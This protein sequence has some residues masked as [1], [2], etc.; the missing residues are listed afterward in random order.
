MAPN[1]NFLT[2]YSVFYLNVQ[3]SALGSLRRGM[4][5]GFRLGWGQRLVKTV[6]R[7]NDH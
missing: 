3:S 5:S 6:K 1:Y 4:T 7:T 2:Y